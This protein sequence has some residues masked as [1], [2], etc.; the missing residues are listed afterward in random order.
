MKNIMRNKNACTET[1]INSSTKTSVFHG[2]SE[3]KSSYCGNEFGSS[4]KSGFFNGRKGFPKQ[5]VCGSDVT[6]YTSGSKTNHG[7]P[8]F[9]CAVS[10]ENGHLFKWVEDGMYEE[11]MD[12]LQR[13]SQN[14]KGIIGLNELKLE[15]ENVK[16][17]VIQCKTELHKFRMNNLK[18]VVWE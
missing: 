7:R 1:D 15:M 10:R 4:S 18:V 2:K 12:L 11:V 9:R 3:E 13:E 14:E 16:D 17:Q 5:C 8:Y 6:I